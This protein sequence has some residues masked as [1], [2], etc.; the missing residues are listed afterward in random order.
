VPMMR[1]LRLLASLL[2]TAGVLVLSAC[3]HEGDDGGVVVS[4]EATMPRISAGTIA[5]VRGANVAVTQVAVSPGVV[6]W[7]QSYEDYPI[8]EIRVF[9]LRSHRARV[10]AKTQVLN[11]GL[12]AAHGR[13][14]DVE[15]RARPT[16]VARRLD[17]RGD[18]KVL[19][20]RVEGE[21]DGR[22]GVVAWGENDGRFQRVVVSSLET[23]RETVVFRRP[24]CGRDYCFRIDA[25]SVADDGVVLARGAVGPGFTE[26]ARQRLGDARPEIWRIE[27]AP[28]TELLRSSAG[29]LVSIPRQGLV[30][31]RFGT[32]TRRTVSVVRSSRETV[33][34]YERP[35]WFVARDGRRPAVLAVRQAAPAV[36]AARPRPARSPRV[37]SLA[38][39]AWTG[40]Q[41]VANWLVRG[42]GSREEEVEANLIDAGRP[43]R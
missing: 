3:D 31:W 10:L 24:R 35:F 30:E 26:I 34:G 1:P 27:G 4:T 11:A 33:L 20:S 13:I 36:V 23:G 28:Q 5:R 15:E 6:A 18:P 40:R 38:A 39:W 7:T 21:F 32:R 29:A 14:V 9:D 22:G 8:S 43:L 25:V 2:A 42:S 19:S 12:V 17:G 41:V 16:L 37:V